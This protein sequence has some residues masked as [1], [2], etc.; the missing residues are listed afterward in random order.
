RVVARAVR[1]GRGVDVIQ[2]AEDL[3]VFLDVL[4]RLHRAVEFEVFAFPRRPPIGWDRSVGKIDEGHPQWRAGRRR[5]ERTAPLPFRRERV[6]RAE[7]FEC[8]QRKARA[9]TAEEMAPAQTGET[10]RGNVRGE[11]RVRFHGCSR[12][13]TPFFKDCAGVASVT[14]ERLRRFWN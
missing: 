9:E 4:Q 10:L 14:A 7:R 12:A 5:R 3:Q 6:E 2:L 8:R 1:A 13:W 11:Q